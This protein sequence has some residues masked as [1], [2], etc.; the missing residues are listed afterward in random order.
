MA[1][2][3]EKIISLKEFK[4]SSKGDEEIIRR[5]KRKERDG[6]IYLITSEIR[7]KKIKKEKIHSEIKRM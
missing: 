1:D 7:K 4:I 6:N 5:E 3:K 2:T